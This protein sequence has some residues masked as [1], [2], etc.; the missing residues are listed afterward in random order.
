MTAASASFTILRDADPVPAA[1]Q[2]AVVAIGNFDG[3]HRGHQAVMG[4]AL[5]MGAAKGKP[6]LALTFEPHPASLFQPGRPFFRLTPEAM[7]LAEIARL[8]LNGAVVMG[9]TPE[10]ASEAPDAFVRRVLVGRLGVSA[11]AVG[12][13]F[14]FGHK[15]QGTPDFLKAE[16]A[17]LGFAVT[18]VPHL[19]DAEGTVSSSTIRA[20]LAQGD[21]A[22]AARLMGRP[23]TVEAVV[24]HGDKRGRT[25]GF[26][27]ANLALDPAVQLAYG[28]YA[29]RVLVGGK[30][31]DGVASH[32]RR[33]TFD[34][35]APLLECFLFDFAG[36]LYGQTLQV[37]LVGWIRPELKFDNVEALVTQMNADCQSARALLAAG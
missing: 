33:P 32:G 37:Q 14:H 5:A 16:G 17:R 7:K 29:V 28:I 15:R 22:R 20:A 10:L 21:V 24:R 19:A 23:F 13:D 31:V 26:P 11:V 3:V 35:G 4:E 6:T 18:I 2:G 25:L 8:G 1:L 12:Y 36:D 9:F 30:L 34:N 27:T